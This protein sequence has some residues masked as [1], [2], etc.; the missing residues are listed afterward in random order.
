MLRGAL[1]TAAVGLG[2]LSPAIA[3]A[4]DPVRIGFAAAKTGLFAGA[5]DGQ[6]KTYELWK[7]E[8]NARGGLDV[9]GVKRPVEFVFYDD[10]SDTGKV[11]QIYEKLITGDK[12][13]LLLA[14][15]GTSAHIGA[16]GVV[17]RYKFPLVGNTA[18]SVKLRELKP[19][20][21]WFTT[22]QMPDRLAKALV[23]LFK[24]KGFK[25]VALLVNQLPL[26]LESKSYLLPA[27]AQAG[28][29]VKVNEEYPPSV[30]DMTTL[31]T[32]VKL[33][34]PDA[35]VAFSFP[36]DSAIYL[37]QA[38][39]L[40]IEAKF[41]FVEVGPTEAAFAKQFGPALNGIVT[42]GH[43]SPDHTQWHGAKELFDAYV[44]RYHEPPSYLNTP[45]VYMS[46]Q[47][48]EQAVAKVG[49]DRDAIRQTIASSTFD[50][51]NGPVKFEGVEN[52]ATPAGL[53]QVQGDKMALIWPPSIATA[54]FV[55]KPPWPAN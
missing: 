51:V 46:C 44:Q 52:V 48:L 6:I 11:V 14:P 8:V 50:T 19:G 27:L 55:P 31:L 36:A 54:D 30:R 33:A 41:Q 29:E 39:E 32:S 20:N 13:D 34:N 43:W 1:L 24:A 23:E 16:A 38:R 42:M 10:Q 17:E 21:I 40:G 4:A 47:I 53:L 35:V 18:A 22:G 7:D 12:V 2:L 9:K 28:I 26:G 49:L 45:L 37:K 25:S 15:Y 5:A 3:H